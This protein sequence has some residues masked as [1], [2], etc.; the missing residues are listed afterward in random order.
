MKKIR[1]KWIVPL[2][3]KRCFALWRPQGKKFHP[4]KVCLE[5]GAEI[6]YRNDAVSI[7][8]PTAEYFKLKPGYYHNGFILSFIDGKLG[9]PKGND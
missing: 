2:E 6:I 4:P 3:G 5:C 8:T 9:D 1:E 7:T